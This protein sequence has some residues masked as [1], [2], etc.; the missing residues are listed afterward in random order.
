MYIISDRLV[1]KYLLA[2]KKYHLKKPKITIRTMTSRWG[3]CTPAKCK[4]TINKNLIYPPQK[5]LEYIVLH[6]LAH[7]I[8]ANHS[9]RFYAI[10]AEIMPNWKERRK[11][12]NEF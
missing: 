5:C 10:I 1:D 6:E 8:E 4:I 9:E 7:L 12:L 2:L 3:S 11:I